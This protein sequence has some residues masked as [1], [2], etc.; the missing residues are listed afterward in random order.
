[1]RLRQV[2]LGGEDRPAAFADVRGDRRLERLLAAAALC[3]D[4][5]PGGRGSPT[6]RA[7]VDAAAEAGLDAARLRAGRPRIAEIPFDST[8]KRMAVLCRSLGG[9]EA[10]VKGAP[11]VV[12]AAADRWW[13]GSRPRPLGPAEHRLWLARAAALADGA[14]RV[15]ALAVRTGV[16]TPPPVERAAGEGMVLLGL[17]GLMDPPRPEARAAVERCEA[18]GV[19]VIMVTGD[20]RRTAAAVARELGLLPGRP[21]GENPP[22]DASDDAAVLDGTQLDSLDDA[23]LRRRLGRVRVFARVSPE[24]KLRIVRLLKQDGEV[25]AM[26]GDGVN[27]APAVKAADIGVAMGRIGADVTREAADMVLLDDNFATIVAAVEEGRAIYANVRKF[28]R[29]IL[30]SNTGEILVML[31]AML[32]GWPLPLLPI[33]ILFVNLVTDGLPAVALGLEPPERDVMQRRPRRPDESLFA[34]GLARRILGWGVVI[35]VVSLGLFAWAA[36]GGDLDR[37]RTITLAS[38]VLSQMFHV[39]ECRAEGRGSGSVVGANPALLLAVATTVAALVAIIHWPPLAGPFRTAPLTGV[40]W[41][42]STGACGLAYVFMRLRRRLLVLVSPRR[43][44][45]PAS[46]LR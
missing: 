42:V 32:L 45:A 2:W 37:A 17:V 21:S 5:E 11:E 7:L 38:L 28:V 31:A 27:D 20:H 33:H 16:G 13:D 24:H 25:V 29:Y 6:E 40:D 43:P 30:A 10:Y 9:W 36:A 4:A 22:G 44:H 46:S 1:M 8:T 12:L 15:L 19:R 34:Q 14:L 35:G 39:L 41:L 18:A 3:S 26:T 23:E